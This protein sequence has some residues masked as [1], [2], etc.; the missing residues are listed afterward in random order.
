MMLIRAAVATL[1]F[2]KDDM[3]EEIWIRDIDRPNEPLK[4]EIEAINGS[5]LRLRVAN[6]AVRFTLRRVNG[7]PYFEGSLGGRDFV[8]DPGNRNAA[9]PRCSIAPRKKTPGTG[10]G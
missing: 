9:A 3:A 5:V 7:N 8:F 6:T 4:A 10:P 2:M 1:F